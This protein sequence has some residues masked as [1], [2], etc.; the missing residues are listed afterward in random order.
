MSGAARPR[1]SGDAGVPVEGHSDG[2]ALTTMG[3]GG[4]GDDSE[5]IFGVIEARGDR[6]WLGDDGEDSRRLDLSAPARGAQRRGD[7]GGSECGEGSGCWEEGS[8][9][10]GGESV[11][12]GALLNA[13]N[14]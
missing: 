10:G 5:A 12:G 2:C 9:R 6:V 4:E 7:R 11:G 13:F 3:R 14:A 1:G 8:G